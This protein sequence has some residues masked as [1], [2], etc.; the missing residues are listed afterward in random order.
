M[1]VGRV[2]GVG[3]QPFVARIGEHGQRQHQGAG[4]AGGDDD[5]LGRYVG[6]EA[7]VVEAG[8]G[9]AQR[10]EA[11]GRRVMHVAAGQKAAAGLDDR[12]RAG[13][14]RLADLQ[15]DDVAAFGGQ[16]VGALEDLHH[17]EGLDVGHA[18]GDLGHR[19]KS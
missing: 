14:V 12:G 1:A 16:G 18:A 11:Q 6:P 15:V 10:G 19:G 17:V 2:T 8:D 13:E 9:L 4:R 3:L 5:A 7:V